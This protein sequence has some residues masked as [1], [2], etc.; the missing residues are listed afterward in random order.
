MCQPADQDQEHRPDQG[1]L[2]VEVRPAEVHLRPA[3]PAVTSR[4]AL[5][6]EAFGDRGHVNPTPRFR[7]RSK[8][9]PCQP[10]HQHFSRPPLER[11]A[12]L[13][14]HGARRLPYQHDLVVGIAAEDGGRQRQKAGLDATGAAEDAAVQV[15]E[16]LV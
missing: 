3:R 11:Y 2:P 14:L 1:E 10:L 15:G 5:S 16:L 6:R 9:R 8:A 13:R 4:G 12:P 7:F